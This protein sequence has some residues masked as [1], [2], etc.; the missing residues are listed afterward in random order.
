MWGQ[1]LNREVNPSPTPFSSILIRLNSTTVSGLE[2][3]SC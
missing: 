2:H 3:F 1:I